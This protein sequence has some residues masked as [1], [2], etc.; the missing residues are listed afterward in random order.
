MDFSIKQCEMLCNIA[1]IDQ[2]IFWLTFQG[3]LATC[4]GKIQQRK[5]RPNIEHVV[6]D[7]EAQLHHEAANLI[8]TINKL[9]QALAKNKSCHASLMKTRLEL[10]AQIDVK[11]N[12]IFIDEVK[13]MSIRQGMNMQAYWK[14][15]KK[16]IYVLLFLSMY[17]IQSPKILNFLETFI[18][19]L[20]LAY[21]CEK[22]YLFLIK[23]KISG[24]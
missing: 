23:A 11:A 1:Q 14:G 19:H 8:E 4:Q 16:S 10:E 24:N 17:L 5:Q 9:E 12:S 13:C 6:D 3:P 20:I 15:R 21:E 18:S 2:Y 22:K 7:V